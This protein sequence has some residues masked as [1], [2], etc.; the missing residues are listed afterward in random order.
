MSDA[1][2]TLDTARTPR[3]GLLQRLR[4]WLD[5]LLPRAGWQMVLAF[6]SGF[7]TY[8]C[9]TGGLFIIVPWAQSA[10]VGGIAVGLVA[11]KIRSSALIGALVALAGSWLA[12]PNAF[13]YIYKFSSGST[14]EKVARVVG[15]VV[16]C[17]VFAVIAN[18]AARRS[19]K[20]AVGVFA[21]ALAIMISGLWFTPLTLN[22]VSTTFSHGVLLP[23]FNAQLEGDQ[24]KATSHTDGVL[25]YRI[26][27]GVD[28]GEEFYSYYSH[29]LHTKRGGPA[30][31]FA[32]FRVPLLFWAWAALPDATSIVVLFLALATV[33]ILSVVLLTA[34]VAEAPLALPVVAALCSYF[35]FF[36]VHIGLL[37]QEHWG[38]AFG[39]V[40]IS[41]Y[42]A[43]LRSEK[44]KAWT[45]AAVAFSVLAVLMRE[46]MAFMLIAGLASAFVGDRSQRRSRVIAWVLGCAVFAAAFGAHVWAAQSYIVSDQQLPRYGGGSFNFMIAGV[47][48]ATNFLG[49]NGWLPLLLA[50]L[51]TL[52]GLVIRDARL[53]VFALASALAPLL[54]C[55]VLGNGAYMLTAEGGKLYV[56]YWGVGGVPLLYALIAP[57][58]SI[59]PGVGDGLDQPVVQTPEET[60]ASV[61]ALPQSPEA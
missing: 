17:V 26:Y 38:A 23:S 4:T 19:A 54:A 46:V 61:E 20:I 47:Y 22:G 37:Q 49:K 43:S 51:G 42:A 25:F 14:G 44:W 8:V 16:V 28:K 30:T 32:D 13:D 35:A 12:M 21:V 56:N 15:A 10:A 11:P 50:G 18:L 57:L 40:A 2:P 55:L 31:S 33:A 41:C 45:Y 24:P 60:V 52:G 27:Q 7:L 39:V 36:T 6:V 59:V 9:T 1:S 53:R 48:Y 34:K 58:F 29:I 3:R 5:G